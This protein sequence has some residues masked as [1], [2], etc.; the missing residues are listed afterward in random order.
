MNLRRPRSAASNGCGTLSLSL[1]LP[2]PQPCIGLSCAA[3]LHI[4]V[5]T[6]F[7]WAG[8]LPKCKDRSSPEGQSRLV[9]WQQSL[10]F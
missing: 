10:A 9:T 8:Q 4:L 7:V 5:L 2:Q 3:V 1:S 6:G